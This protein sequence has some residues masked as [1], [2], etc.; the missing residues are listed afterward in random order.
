ML[1]ELKKS[2]STFRKGRPGER[3]ESFYRARKQARDSSRIVFLVV[4]ILLLV[5]GV[6]L[7]FIPGPGILLIAFGGALVAQQSLWMAKLLDEIELFGRKV[8]R[9]GER[10]WKRASVPIRALVVF[11]AAA[12]SGAAGYAAYVWLFRG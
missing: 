8:F 4:G 10:F 11:V 12:G 6:I 1:A 5:G 9:F 2:W 7:L 3:F